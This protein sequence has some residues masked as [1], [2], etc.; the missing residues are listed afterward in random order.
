VWRTVREKLH[1]HAVNLNA[2]AAAVTRHLQSQL[3]T[4]LLDQL[5]KLAGPDAIKGPA[6]AAA[7]AAV[8]GGQHM[9]PGLKPD[10]GPSSVLPLAAAAP[11]PS[12]V[13][14]AAG[15]GSASSSMWHAAMRCLFAEY[16]QAS[17]CLFTLSVFRWVDSAA[18][19]A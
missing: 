5:R 17:G 16:L 15:A 3:R 13:A 2:A 18:M 6:L 4:Q 8:P 1:K 11:G 19:L 7:A 14:A 10:Q 9:H 12:A